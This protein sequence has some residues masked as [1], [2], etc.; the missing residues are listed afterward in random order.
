MLKWK[1]GCCIDKISSILDQMGDLDLA[2][3]THPVRWTTAQISDVLSPLKEGGSYGCSL[4]VSGAHSD[5]EERIWFFWG[6]HL[7][8]PNPSFQWR[9]NLFS[10]D[11]I[12]WFTS[13]R[14][15]ISG[16]ENGLRLSIIL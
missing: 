2:N 6:F 1:Y 9:Q 14:W 10:A 7:N 3:T 5:D 8:H 11:L 4:K 13:P 15:T 12:L 16:L